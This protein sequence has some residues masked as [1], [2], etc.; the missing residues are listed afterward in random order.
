MGWWLIGLV[1]S[2]MVREQSKLLAVLIPV[3]YSEII[4]LTSLVTNFVGLGVERASL[5]LKTGADK[6]PLLTKTTPYLNI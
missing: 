2:Y 1:K 3:P 4:S 5:A 6:I